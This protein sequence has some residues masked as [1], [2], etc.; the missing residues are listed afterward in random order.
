M[1]L[2]YGSAST[3]GISTL[4]LL[5]LLTLPALVLLLNR[6]RQR[7]SGTPESGERLY[8]DEDGIATP[9]SQQVFAGAIPKHVLLATTAAG[10]C[11]SIAAAVQSPFHFRHGRNMALAPDWFTI[12]AWVSIS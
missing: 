10:L 5:S 2:T 9:E 6:F 1:D 11:V 7:P 4:V 8:E 3:A 12:L